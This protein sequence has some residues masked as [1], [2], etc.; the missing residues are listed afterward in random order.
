[1]FGKLNCRTVKMCFTANLPVRTGPEARNVFLSYSFRNATAA[2]F[3]S[4]Q[5][6]GLPARKPPQKRFKGKVAALLPKAMEEGM[7]RCD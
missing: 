5:P 2:L 4:R 6:S 1:V 7:P 3:G